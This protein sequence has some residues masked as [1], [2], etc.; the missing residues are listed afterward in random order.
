M[1]SEKEEMKFGHQVTL[2]ILCA[3]LACVSVTYVFGL[4]EPHFV[5]AC[6]TSQVPVDP[7]ET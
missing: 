3:F 1:S 4:F 2:M 6:E 5:S 7:S